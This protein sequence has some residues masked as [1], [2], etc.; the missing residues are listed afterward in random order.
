MAD[1]LLGLRKSRLWFSHRARAQINYRRRLRRHRL[2]WKKS[3]VITL[4]TILDW[5]LIL[6]CLSSFG[7]GEEELATPPI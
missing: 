7:I 4:E 2:K 6:V 3:Q 5:L 1:R